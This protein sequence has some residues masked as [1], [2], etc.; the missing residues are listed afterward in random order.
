MLAGLLLLV[1]PSLQSTTIHI[2][3]IMKKY[4]VTRKYSEVK[5][6]KADV[7]YYYLLQLSWIRIYV[8]TNL[9]VLSVFSSSDAGR[10][11]IH[12]YSLCK[13]D[14]L[15]IYE[16]LLSRVLK[17]FIIFNLAISFSSL[18]QDHQS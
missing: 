1:W 17:H 7:K 15:H 9:L 16:S 12:V 4:F 13:F 11:S 14:I 10:Q 6:G 2:Y 18:F 3:H 8:E 5:A